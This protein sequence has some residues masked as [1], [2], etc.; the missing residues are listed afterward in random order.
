MNILKDLRKQPFLATVSFAAFIH[1]AWTFATMFAGFEPKPLHGLDWW[2]WWFPGAAIA[3]S[4]DIGILSIAH[5]IRHGERS[6]PTIFVF[7]TLALGMAYA[8]FVFMSLHMPDYALANGVRKS[9]SEGVQLGLD[10]TLF[11]FPSF[12]PIALIMYAF[13][14]KNVKLT[15]ENVSS[16]SQNPEIQR[17]NFDDTPKLGTPI[18]EIENRG[19][20]QAFLPTFANGNGKHDGTD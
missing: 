18:P 12:L 16:D 3:F 13:V 9:W 4:V 15:S 7:V 19:Q 17:P 2:A 8:Q 6:L 10:S 20:K 1:S 14:E 5:R 11:A